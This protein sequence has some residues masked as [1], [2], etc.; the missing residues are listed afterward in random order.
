MVAITSHIV[1]T[2]MSW[3]EL[4]C[5]EMLL[6]RLLEAESR[7]SSLVMTS[8]SWPDSSMCVLELSWLLRCSRRSMGIDFLAW[9]KQE[10][11]TRNLHTGKLL[12]R[13]WEIWLSYLICEHDITK[14]ASPVKATLTIEI[15]PTDIIMFPNQQQ[16]LHYI[17]KSIQSP[18]QIIEIRCSNHFYGHRCIKIKHLR[19]QTVSTN[20]CE[21][22][23]RSQELSE[24]Q[25]GTVIRCHLCNKSSHEISS[26]WHQWYYN[27]VEVNGND[28]NSAAKW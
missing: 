17:A 28:S 9:I 13:S 2:E 1:Y 20:M 14:P 26:L 24:F 12:L 27:K 15:N 11:W 21:R 23:S 16:E 25:C 18:I 5:E 19:M 7:G 4:T 22:M 6:L 10:R 3:T 8:S